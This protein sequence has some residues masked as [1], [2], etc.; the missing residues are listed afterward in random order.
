MNILQ[1]WFKFRP[2]I[3]L[4]S[5]L[6]LL[7]S[8]NLLIYDIFSDKFNSIWFNSCNFNTFRS[9]NKNG[10]SRKKVDMEKDVGFLYNK[11]HIFYIIKKKMK[12]K[13]FLNDS[14][15]SRFWKVMSFQLTSTCLRSLFYTIIYRLG[16]KAFQYFILKVQNKIIYK[17]LVIKVTNI[18]CNIKIIHHSI[19]MNSLT[20][21]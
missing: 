7:P 20:K 16:V 8:Q 17:K 6:I 10:R 18:L 21:T 3:I 5:L 13:S 9:C 12:T 15:K 2:V 14:R 1:I 19:T 4:Q 11:K